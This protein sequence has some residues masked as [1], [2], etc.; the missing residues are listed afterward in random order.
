[1][2]L[3]WLLRRSRQTAEAKAAQKL[4]ASQNTPKGSAALQ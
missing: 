1:V 2:A 4:V 3:P